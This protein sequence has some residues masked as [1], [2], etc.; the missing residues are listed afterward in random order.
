MTKDFFQGKSK[1]VNKNTFQDAAKDAILNS[2]RSLRSSRA[3]LLYEG[4]KA[5]FPKFDNLPMPVIA[6]IPHFDYKEASQFEKTLSIGT[7]VTL[8]GFSTLFRRLFMQHE[9]FFCHLCILPRSFQSLHCYWALYHVQTVHLERIC[10]ICDL[11]I[12]SKRSALFS[13]IYERHN[14]QYDEYR[15]KFSSGKCELFKAVIVWRE[16]FSL[17]MWIFDVDCLVEQMQYLVGVLVFSISI[18]CKCRLLRLISKK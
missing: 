7:V 13:H 11:T 17:I 14:E 6:R 18:S 10:P 8:R 2:S 3:K 1:R 16:S 12:S 5:D 15:M 9:K 4:L